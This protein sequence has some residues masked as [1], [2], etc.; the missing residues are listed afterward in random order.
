MP[1]FYMI[2]ARKIIKIPEF[3]N[4]ICLQNLQNSRILHDFCREMP[5]FY[6]MIDRKIFF[7]NFRGARAVPSLPPVC[8]AYGSVVLFVNSVFDSVHQLLRAYRTLT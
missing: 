6:I 8:Y 4:D 3:F 2:L 1:E 7:P 5:E